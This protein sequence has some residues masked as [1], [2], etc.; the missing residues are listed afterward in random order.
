MCERMLYMSLDDIVEATAVPAGEEKEKTTAR[1]VATLRYLWRY[2]R[3]GIF[4]RVEGNKLVQLA[5]FANPFFEN[6]WDLRRFLSDNKADWPAEARH[7]AALPPERWWANAGI[8]CTRPVKGVWGTAFLP[9]VRRCLERAAALRRPSAPRREFFFNKRDFPNIRRDGADPFAVFFG[10]QCKPVVRLDRVLPIFSC[11]T[12]P[13]FAD[14]PFPL[15]QD[16]TLVVDDYNPLEF[17][18]FFL[19]FE[20]RAPKAI[21]RGSLTGCGNTPATNPRLRL[22]NLV[23]GGEIDAE[24]SA[25]LV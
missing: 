23:H 15:M 22:F 24:R 10:G 21:F 5:P 4:V 13:N 2:C 9:E 11:Y 25:R 6:E 18:D 7:R 12:G 20:R 8:L 1:R 17:Q 16:Y 3:C 14:W 19:D